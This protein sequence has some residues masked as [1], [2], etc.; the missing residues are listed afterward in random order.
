MSLD[1]YNFQIWAGDI[2]RR[3]LCKM[4]KDSKK[5]KHKHGDGSNKKR[6]H[7][8]GNILLVLF[9]PISVQYQSLLVVYYIDLAYSTF[10]F[11]FV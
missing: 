2:K 8:S 7:K 3:Y 9:C 10:N 5:K 6:V 1:L 11:E 4:G